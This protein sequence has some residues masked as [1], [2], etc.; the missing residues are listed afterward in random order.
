L[1]VVAQNGAE[2]KLTPEEGME[3]LKQV[4][5]TEHPFG[6]FPSM[7]SFVMVG[8]GLAMVLGGSWGRLEW[9]NRW[10]YQFFYAHYNHQRFAWQ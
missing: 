10:S 3:K 9:S 8:A 1:A 7:L 6:Y 2:K 5:E 4:D